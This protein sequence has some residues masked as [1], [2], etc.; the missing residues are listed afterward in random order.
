MRSLWSMLSLVAAANRSKASFLIS[1][2]LSVWINKQSVL[3]TSAALLIHRKLS[4]N[5]VLPSIGGKDS[6]G[7]LVPL[8][9]IYWYINLS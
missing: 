6:W 8:K 9:E 7:C 5:L 4:F 1:G 3:P 2:I